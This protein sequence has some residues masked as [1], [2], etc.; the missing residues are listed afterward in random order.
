MIDLF[1]S[2][3]KAVTRYDVIT[4]PADQGVAALISLQQI[5]FW[6][7]VDLVII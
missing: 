6:I 5:V 3:W 2:W 7:G 4:L 1:S